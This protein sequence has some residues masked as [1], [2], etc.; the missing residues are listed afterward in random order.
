M[1]LTDTAARQ[2]KP[3]EAAY[4]LADSG[5]LYLLVQ[6][7]GAKYWRL[8][9]RIAGKEKVLALGVYPEVKLAEART[10]RDEAKKLISSGTDPIAARR[11]EERQKKIRAGN[12]FEAIAR[13]WHEQQRGRWTD[14]T[15]GRAIALLEADL[16]PSLGDRPITEITAPMVLE[17]VRKV[18]KRGA[19]DV[20]SRA[21]QRAKAVFRYA[22][23]TGRAEYNPA[24]DLAGALKTRKV[25]HRAALGRSELPELLRKIEAYDGQPVTRL[26][27]RLVVL[28]FVRSGELREASWEE[29]DLERAEWRIPAERMKM[30]APHIVPLSSQAVAILKELQPLTG[31]YPLVFPGQNDH[32]RPMSEN[33][34]L[35]AMYRMGYHGRAT[36][37]GFRATASTILNESGF[38][39]DAIERQ[40][41]HAERNKVRAAYHR[42]EYL[43]E[44]KKMM[45]WWADFLDGIAKGA[46][47]IPLASKAR[48]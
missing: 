7:N 30:R 16:F 28:T 25:E 47:V 27:L 32:E 2:A 39:H 9:Y 3:K 46:D 20:A 8:K 33:T 34:L 1:P 35:Y 38:R 6:P 44:R 42:S 5:G 41:A 26:A 29:F 14:D 31:R 48:A 21:L 19:L 45:Q 17:A 37:H 15:A 18:E 10:K 13:E 12:S 23:Q 22:I 43:E 4:K 24:S 40:L 11:E 36:V